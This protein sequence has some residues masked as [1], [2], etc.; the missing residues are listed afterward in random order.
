MTALY[1]EEEQMCSQYNRRSRLWELTSSVSGVQLL[2]NVVLVSAVW[3]SESAI[4]IHIPC[5]C[6]HRVFEEISLCHIVGSHCYCSVAVMSKVSNSLR[7]HRPQHARLPHPSLSPRVC[8]DSCPLGQW[9]YLTISSA[10]PFLDSTKM[11]SLITRFIHSSVYM[12][13]G[14]ENSLYDLNFASGAR[15]YPVWRK[16]MSLQEIL[17]MQI[18]FRLIFVPKLKDISFKIIR[19]NKIF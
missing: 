10:A 16:V 4:C 11:F 8:S 2:Y 19:E 18:Y 6:H 15:R 7:P 14:M 1:I 13:I 5:L 3:L 9:C 12:L 17:G